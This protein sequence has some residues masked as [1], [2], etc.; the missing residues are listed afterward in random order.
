M[1]DNQIIQLYWER[2]EQA[3]VESERQY[4]A[5]C[6]TVAMNILSNPQD[7]EEC[8]NDTWLKSWQTIP[9]KRPPNLCAFFCRIARNLSL[10]RYRRKYMTQARGS[11]FEVALHE[12]SECLPSDETIA[13]TDP[14]PSLLDGYL[15]TLDPTHRKL[16]VGRYWHAYP[17]KRLAAAYG[18]T[19]NHVSVI[20]HRLRDDLRSYFNERGYQ[21]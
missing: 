15:A 8:V 10:D 6:H 11:G 7:A 20:L 3:I 13:G 2:D 16:F 1:N 9:P 5:L 14:L 21:I 4:G 12:L 19:P 17:V 18:M